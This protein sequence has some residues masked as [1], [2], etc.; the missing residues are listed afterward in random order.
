MMAEKCPK[1]QKSA[2]N[3]KKKKH[4]IKVT[5]FKC[6]S[7]EQYKRLGP[8]FLRVLKIKKKLIFS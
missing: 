1:N 4:I 7:R 6:L 8:H 3:V 5:L 2:K